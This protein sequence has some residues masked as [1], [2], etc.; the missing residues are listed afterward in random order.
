M[1]VGDIEDVALVAEVA[2]DHGFSLGNEQGQIVAIQQAQ[3]L[4]RPFPAAGAAKYQFCHVKHIVG[5]GAKERGQLIQ[6]LKAL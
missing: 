6:F 5:K 3:C 1:Q 4:P 2:I